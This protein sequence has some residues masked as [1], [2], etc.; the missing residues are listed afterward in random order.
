MSIGEVARRAGIAPSA[1]RYYESLGLLP[2]PAR[3]SGQRRYD[4]SVLEWLSLI[5]LAREAGFT[6]AEVGQL[7]A[8]FVPGTPPAAQWRA[9]AA[10][11][12]AEIDAQVARAE[13]MRAVLTIALDCGCF[14][15]EDCASLLDAGPLN[16]ESPCVLPAAHR[17]LRAADG[18]F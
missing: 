2:A 8:G 18:G 12:L 13:R 6:M 14:R 5:A 16:G 4:A 11:K 1:I 10:R 7:V 3:A 15:L 17:A 9:L